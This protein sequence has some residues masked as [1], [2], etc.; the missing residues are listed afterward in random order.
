MFWIIILAWSFLFQ[1]ILFY[2]QFMYLPAEFIDISNNFSEANAHLVNYFDKPD[3]NNVIPLQISVSNSSSTDA[4]IKKIAQYL[5]SID[6]SVAGINKSAKVSSDIT[7]YATL[8]RT[9]TY[10]MTF[11]FIVWWFL[12][13]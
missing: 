5:E 10:L 1:L 7:Y 4:D 2:D 3:S 13:R 11:S 8:T 12:I 9:T 6:K